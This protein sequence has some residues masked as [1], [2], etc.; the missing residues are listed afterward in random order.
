MW[1]ESV[2]VTWDLNL[3]DAQL[4]TMFLRAS[5]DFF[6]ESKLCKFDLMD[7]ISTLHL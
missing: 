7:L 2:P 3:W 6:E 1:T 4:L 5:R